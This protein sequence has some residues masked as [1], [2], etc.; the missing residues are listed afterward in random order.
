MIE[1]FLIFLDQISAL[2]AETRDILKSHI[3]RREVAKGELILEHGEICKHLYYVESGF[4]R[5]F[6]YKNGKEITEWFAG[7]RDMLFS[8]T[9]FL[10]QQPSNLIIEATEDTRLI[11]FSREVYSSL[12]KTNIE[13]SNLMMKMFAFSLML[14]QERMDSIQFETAEKRYDKL[15]SSQP[16]IFLKATLQHIASYLGITPETLSRIRNKK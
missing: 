9:S 4:T 12:S 7:E 6:Y 11:Q 16:K 8:I 10:K 13:A 1:D 15:I 5:I 14:S 2:S 3:S